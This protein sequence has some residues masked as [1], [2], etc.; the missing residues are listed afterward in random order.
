[1]LNQDCVADL[2]RRKRMC[3]AIVMFGPQLLRTS[4]TFFKDVGVFLLL[5]RERTT[6]G[7]KAIAHFA[8]EDNLSW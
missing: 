8:I 6:M 5:G 2:E 4:C 3:S 7:W 1:M